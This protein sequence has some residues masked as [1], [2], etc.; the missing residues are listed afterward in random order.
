MS[1]GEP[2]LDG[3]SDDER[4]HHHHKDGP[5]EPK[6]QLELPVALVGYAACQSGVVANADNGHGNGD[7]E[8]DGGSREHQST[9]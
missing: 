2:V 5:H 1:L 6:R 9:A 3:Q 4:K 7:D 8:S